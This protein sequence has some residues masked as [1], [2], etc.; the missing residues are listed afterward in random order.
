V[1]VVHLGLIRASRTRQLQQLVRFVAREIPADVPL[2]VA[3]DF[4]EWGPAMAR[5]LNPAGLVAYTQGRH[6]TFPSRV[7]MV[8][9][10][11]VYARGLQ[12]T[13]LSVPHGRIWWRMSDHLPLIAEF[14]W[15]PVRG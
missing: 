7:P 5:I 1:L 12:P 6:P 8:Q 10:D 11:H 13:G 2:V 9:L 15:K 14:E 4:N 3:G